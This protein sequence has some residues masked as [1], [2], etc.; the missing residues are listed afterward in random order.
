MI[1]RKDIDPRHRA[2]QAVHAGI[3]A[4]RDLIP[5]EEQHPNLV[6][7]TVDNEQELL[8]WRQIAEQDWDIRTHLFHEADMRDEATAFSTEPIDGELRPCFKDLPLLE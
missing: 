1:V 3:Q 8:D 6:I 2:V 7:L 5:D 4:G